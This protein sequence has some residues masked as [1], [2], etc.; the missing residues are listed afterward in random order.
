MGK[1]TNRSK[2][3]KRP[4]KRSEKTNLLKNNS[5]VNSGKPNDISWYNKNPLLLKQAGTVNFLM[6]QGRLLK[7]EQKGIVS[8]FHWAGAGKTFLGTY[9]RIPGIARLGWIPTPGIAIDAVSPINKSMVKY[10][11]KLRLKNLSI[12]AYDPADVGFYLLAWDSVMAFYGYMTLIYGHAKS[13]NFENN[14]YPKAILKALNVNFNDIIDHLAEFVEY[15][16]VIK[17]ALEKARIPKDWT[18]ALRH[19]HMSAQVYKDSPNNK[20]QMYVFVPDVVYKYN[21]TVPSLDPIQVGTRVTPLTF[22][23]IKEICNDLLDAIIP[24]EDLQ[25]I[26]A[27]MEKYF[28]GNWIEPQDLSWE[29][30]ATPVYNEEMLWQIHNSNFLPYTDITNANITQE[31]NVNMDAI[32]KWNPTF[33]VSDGLCCCKRILDSK[34]EAPSPE[35]VIESTRLMYTVNTIT[36]TAEFEFNIT[37]ASCGSEILTSVQIIVFD[38][39]NDLRVQPVTTFINSVLQN[40]SESVGRVMCF[41]LE[42]DQHNNVIAG[43]D[44]AS[45]MYLSQFEYLPILYVGTSAGPTSMPCLVGIASQLDNYAVL[46][47]EQLAIIHEQTLLSEFDL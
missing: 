37:L 39:N 29:S 13:W 47:D 24:N 31:I 7:I 14:Y 43:Q 11:T 20:A 22:A 5:K 3:F 23:N 6:P 36:Q 30:T 38:S 34:A 32:I 28:E 44:L 12:S 17:H 8:G 40:P 16:D 25:I 10:F 46:D 4:I 9:K 45:M 42:D 2:N 18:Y 21:A 41:K 35:E 19:M 1:Q 33:K 26:A 15:I 27:D